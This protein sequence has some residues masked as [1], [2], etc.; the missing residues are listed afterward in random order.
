MLTLIRD[1]KD[2]KEKGSAE[3]TKRS[4]DVCL[5]CLDHSESDYTHA[6]KKKKTGQCLPLTVGI[7]DKGIGRRKF[8]FHH[9]HVCIFLYF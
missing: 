9:I 2:A 3:T 5:P 8:I 4:T 6:F 1:L 7:A